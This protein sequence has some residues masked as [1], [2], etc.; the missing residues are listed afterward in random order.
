MC[1]SMLRSICGVVLR[2]VVFYGV[3]FGG[4]VVLFVLLNFCCSDAFYSG[5]VALLVV[6]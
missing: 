6:V 4:F 3:S 5:C 2:F 1:S